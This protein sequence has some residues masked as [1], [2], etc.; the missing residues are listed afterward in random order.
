[1]ALGNGCTGGTGETIASHT[2]AVAAFD[3]A[4]ISEV[5]GKAATC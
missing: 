4:M 3:E 5:N 1:M 2:A